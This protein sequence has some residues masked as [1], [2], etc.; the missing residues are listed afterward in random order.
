MVFII[1]M[2]NSLRGPQSWWTPNFY[3]DFYSPLVDYL[4]RE[5][6]GPK[7]LVAASNHRSQ[8]P[9]QIFYLL[10]LVCFEFEFFFI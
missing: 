7:N 6:C 4:T 8:R 2:I 3:K 10:I 9:I 5:I 1:S